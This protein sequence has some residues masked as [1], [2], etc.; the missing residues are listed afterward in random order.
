MIGPNASEK[1]GLQ[2]KAHAGLIVARRV[3]AILCHLLMGLAQDAELVLHMVAHLM[4]DDIG[5]SEVAVSAKFFLHVL[6]KLQVDVNTLVG[7]A[8]ERTAGRSRIATA[9]VDGIAEDDELRGLVGLA[10]L[11]ELFG[12]HILGAG[13]NLA[14]EHPEVGFPL[15]LNI[16]SGSLLGLGRG[17]VLY[18]LTGVATQETD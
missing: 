15:F 2:L 16:F 4:G 8:I 6:E 1:V 5:V 10:H 13:K 14:C 17:E 12:P 11:A 18:H 7:G 9:R 3:L